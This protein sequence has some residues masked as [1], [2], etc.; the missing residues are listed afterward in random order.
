MK[1]VGALW[2]WIWPLGWHT[3][4]YFVCTF[5]S[6]NA[7]SGQNY[8]NTWQCPVWWAATHNGSSPCS[9]FVSR[10]MCIILTSKRVPIYIVADHQ[11][12]SVILLYKISRTKGNAPLNVKSELRWNT[13]FNCVG[14]KWPYTK[15]CSKKAYKGSW[16]AAVEEWKERHICLPL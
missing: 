2:D 5:L 1:H 7:N 6:L 11:S 9:F 13:N 10:Q 8:R 16:E 12:K 15:S 3:V 4:Y 14:C